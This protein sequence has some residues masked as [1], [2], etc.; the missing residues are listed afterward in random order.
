LLQVNLAPPEALHRVA[1]LAE[2][3]DASVILSERGDAQPLPRH[4]N[5]RLLAA[6]NPATGGHSQMVSSAFHRTQ[7]LV[8]MQEHS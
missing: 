8:C 4:P 5:F 3:A 6:M 7:S 1:A 2:A